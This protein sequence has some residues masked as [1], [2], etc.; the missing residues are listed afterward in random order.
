[1]TDGILSASEDALLKRLL[2]IPLPFIDGTPF[3]VEG[4]SLICAAKFVIALEGQQPFHHDRPCLL[5]QSERFETAKDYLDWGRFRVS[6]CE[7]VAAAFG[8]HSGVGTSTLVVTGGP[9]SVRAIRV[10]AA[11]V[12]G[13]HERVH[14]DALIALELTDGRSLTF[15]H[16]PGVYEGVCLTLGKPETLGSPDVQERLVIR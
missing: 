4:G 12:V 6:S 2:G 5:L 3:L 11:T 16:A 13:V 14:Y 9:V 15:G 8:E 10:G 1:M 7:S